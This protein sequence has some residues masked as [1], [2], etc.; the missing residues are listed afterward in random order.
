MFIF[1]ILLMAVTGILQA[2]SPDYITFCVFTFANALGTS[3]VYPLAFIIGNI[4]I[5]LL[6]N[7]IYVHKIHVRNLAVCLC[8]LDIQDG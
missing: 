2:V 3:G 8:L 7:F 4:L 5:L 6:F 1:C